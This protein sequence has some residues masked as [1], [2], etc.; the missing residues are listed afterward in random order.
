[1]TITCVRTLCMADS[2]RWQLMIKR[3]QN[4]YVIFNVYIIQTNNF[5]NRRWHYRIPSIRKKCYWRVHVQQTAFERVTT[6][7]TENVNNMRLFTRIKTGQTFKRTL[8]LYYFYYFVILFR[9]DKF[10]N[11]GLVRPCLWKTSK[12]PP[13][14]IQFKTF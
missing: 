9:Q 8:H 1:M 13:Q 10:F 14:Y 6:T 11:W 3:K 2:R 4:G 12:P 7:T 5:F